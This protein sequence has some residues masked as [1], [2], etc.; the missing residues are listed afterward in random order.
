MSK[1]GK[2]REIILYIDVIYGWIFM[3]MAT[4]DGGHAWW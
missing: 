2:P 3:K 1:N 4:N